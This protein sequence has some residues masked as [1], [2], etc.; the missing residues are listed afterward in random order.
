MSGFI[1]GSAYNMVR[2]IADGFI[3][4]T[5]RTFH[6]FGPKD[7]AD[8]SQEANRFLQEIRSNQPALTEIEAIQK[9]QLRM[10]RLQQALTLAAAALQR[11]R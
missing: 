1:G 10:R 4:V 7:F 9:R 3:A 8:F 2:D 5:N 11:Q 6:N